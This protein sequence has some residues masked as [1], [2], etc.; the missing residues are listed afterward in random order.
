MGCSGA[1][2]SAPLKGNTHARPRCLGVSQLHLKVK[3][4]P[5]RLLRPQTVSPSS[6][7]S[8]KPHFP[9]RGHPRTP[10]PVTLTRGSSTRGH[11]GQ[12]CVNT[13]GHTEPA[14]PRWSAERRH[15]GRRRR[16]QRHGAAKSHVLLT[17]ASPTKP[18]RPGPA[19]SPG[20]RDSVSW[21]PH[22]PGR[23]GPQPSPQRR[24]ARPRQAEQEQRHRF[25]PSDG[26]PTR[27]GDLPVRL[28]GE[29][30]PTFSRASFP[31]GTKTSR[32]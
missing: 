22:S 30:T 11:C 17:W 15:T 26:A 28:P 9:S 4:A 19:L 5:R 21:P 14:P 7:S 3:A 13:C 31:G 16:F 24:E 23:A 27:P 2:P 25:G 12:A 10:F 6:T 32:Q 8:R 1:F 18:P 29:E 20:S